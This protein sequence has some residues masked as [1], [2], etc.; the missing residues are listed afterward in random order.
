[1]VLKKENRRRILITL[2]II[3]NFI[4]ILKSERNKEKKLRYLIRFQHIV[5]LN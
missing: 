2:A 5:Y 1:M 3:C 4:A